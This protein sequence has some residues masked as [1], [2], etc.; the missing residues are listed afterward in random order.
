MSPQKIRKTPSLNSFPGWWFG[1]SAKPSYPSARI[2]FSGARIGYNFARTKPLKTKAMKTIAKTLVAIII[3]M[4][5]LQVIA[6]GNGNSTTT[7]KVHYKVQI[8][9]QKDVPFKT[10]NVFVVMSD[11]NNKLVAAPQ[12]LIYGKTSYEFYE[13]QTV[14]GTRVASL[15][16][17]DGNIT[18]L[19]HSTRD[20]QNGKFGVGGTY[21]FNLYVLITD[22]GVVAGVAAE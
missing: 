13:S 18:G 22:P 20:V 6:G 4:I 5:S 9:L 11:E 8:H 12:L 17:T 19:F 2:N 7:G 10:K 3:M 14:I 21:L 16:Y 1:F 15:I